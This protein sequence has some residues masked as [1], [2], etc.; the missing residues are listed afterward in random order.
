M[1]QKEERFI[2]EFLIDNGCGAGTVNELLEDNFSCQC[3]EDLK[4]AQGLNAQEIGGF[5]SS[6]EKKDILW[7][8]DRIG[9]P[10]LFW[11]NDSF[12]EEISKE[13]GDIEFSRLDLSGL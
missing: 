9:D 13:Q 5:I 1:T 7:I 10:D 2:K 4:E 12:L 6:L 11:V 8:E 3:V